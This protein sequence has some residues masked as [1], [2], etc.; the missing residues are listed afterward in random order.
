M[1]LFQKSKKIGKKFIFQKFSEKYLL[2]KRGKTTSNK[3]IKD[4]LKIQKFWG[5]FYFLKLKSKIRVE[6]GRSR[7][8]RCHRR[9]MDIRRQSLKTMH[10]L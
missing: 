2:K 1:N 5:I 6:T 4:A 3:V 10:Y 9:F 8:H 7:G